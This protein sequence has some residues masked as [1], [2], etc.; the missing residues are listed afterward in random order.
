MTRKII[1]AAVVMIAVVIGISTTTINAQTQDVPTL[2]DHIPELEA[3]VENQ[4][5][6]ALE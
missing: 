4:H 3:T 2:P 1:G 6:T 5:T